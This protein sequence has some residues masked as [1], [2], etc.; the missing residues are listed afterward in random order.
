MDS[1]E[2]KMRSPDRILVLNKV[3]PKQGTGMIDPEAFGG[4]N[5]LHAKMDP[6]TTFWYLQYERG[7][8]PEPL[9]QR[10]TSFKTLLKYAGEYFEKRNIS[11]KEVK[12]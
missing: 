12:D 8:L 11:I 9:K 4:N 5:P 10:Y 1:L 6:Q 2:S 3:D 7:V